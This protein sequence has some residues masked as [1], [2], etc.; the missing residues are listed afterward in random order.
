VTLTLPTTSTVLRVVTSAAVSLDVCA[1]WVDLLNTGVLANPP[2][3]DSLA[4]IASA[5]TTT[6]VA[7][8]ASSTVRNVKA[9]TLRNKDA[10]LSDD[11]TVQRYNGTTAY[12][13]IK[14]TVG[15]GET[16]EFAEGVGWFKPTFAGATYKNAFLTTPTSISA[17]TYP[18][19]A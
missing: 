5:A 19:F 1:D 11:V 16:L 9:V 2:S 10:S 15:P 7:A 18:H 17:A 3:G 8:P 6:I 14:V 12:D 13:V 4:N